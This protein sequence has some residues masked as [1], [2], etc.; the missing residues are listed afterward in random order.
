[1]SEHAPSPAAVPAAVP[2]GLAREL[3]VSD[4]RALR[5]SLVSAVRRTCPAQL[6]ADAD[7]I[8]QEA[9]LRVL[10]A[11][12]VV[13]NQR[14]LHRVATCATIDALRRRRSA[15][16]EL[17]GDAVPETRAGAADPAGILADRQLGLA[18]RDC[19]AE[20]PDERRRTIEL[21]LLGHTVPELANLLGF[22]DKSSENLVYRG[23]KLLRACLRAKGFTP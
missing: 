15:R 13:V 9:M 3:P 1:M 4:L 7:D 8:V 10:R 11:D 18:I 20:Q 5:A 2:A 6:A 22:G 17:A 19:L 21:Y 23:L 12:A 14:Y 16:L